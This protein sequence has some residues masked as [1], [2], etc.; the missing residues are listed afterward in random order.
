MIAMLSSGRALTHQ[1][2]TPSRMRMRDL[3]NAAV[4]TARLPFPCICRAREQEA[5]D[6]RILLP[7]QQLAQQ[8]LT[9]VTQ[10]HSRS[11]LGQKRLLE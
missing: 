11:C 4:R 8:G 1:G 9:D 3:L 6:R 10:A 5:T 2:S 7:V